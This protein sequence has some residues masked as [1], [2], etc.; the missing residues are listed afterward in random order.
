M[1][2]SECAEVVAWWSSGA[3]AGG[4]LAGSGNWMSWAA[5]GAGALAAT[6]RERREGEEV[7]RG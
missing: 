7:D 5:L 3:L 1:D 4:F 6:V 2:L